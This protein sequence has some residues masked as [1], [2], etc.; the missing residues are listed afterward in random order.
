[1]FAP[2]I[3]PSQNNLCFWALQIYLACLMFMVRYVRAQLRHSGRLRRK[4]MSCTMV[5][6]RLVTTNRIDATPNHLGVFVMNSL[7]RI[8]P[9]RPVGKE[10]RPVSLGAESPRENIWHP[11]IVQEEKTCSDRDERRTPAQR[12]GQLSERAAKW[13]C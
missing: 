12:E 11:R 13:S 5:I 2:I 8:R 4:N 6:S 9:N 10:L 3:K 1:M 7:E